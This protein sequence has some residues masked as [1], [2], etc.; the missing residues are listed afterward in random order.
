MVCTSFHIR[1]LVDLLPSNKWFTVE[2]GSVYSAIIFYECKVL[3][4]V[5]QAH[6]NGCQVLK[7]KHLMG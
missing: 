5:T 3:N 6:C 1:R 4:K 7:F 2:Q